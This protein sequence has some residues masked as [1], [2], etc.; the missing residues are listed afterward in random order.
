VHQ[1]VINSACSQRSVAVTAGNSTESIG[2]V[3]NGSADDLLLASSLQSAPQLGWAATAASLVSSPVVQSN[4]FSV[5]DEE[6]EGGGGHGGDDGQF[7][8]VLSQRALKRRRQFSTQP[9]PSQQQSLAVRAAADQAYPRQYGQRQQSKRVM[10][11]RATASGSLVA[12]KP[13]NKKLCSVWIT[14]VHRIVPMM[15]EHMYQVCP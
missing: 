11:G 13:I 9:S 4:R 1:S 12:A 7:T 2:Q 10:M 6:G 14:L 8:E 3:T 5:F 15:C